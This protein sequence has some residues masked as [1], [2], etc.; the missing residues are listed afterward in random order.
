MF[1]MP[2]I[3]IPTI[4]IINPKKIANTKVINRFLSKV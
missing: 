3:I 4:E 2:G 1:N